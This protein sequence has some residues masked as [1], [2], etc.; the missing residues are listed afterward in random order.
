[1]HSLEKPGKTSEIGDN[2]SISVFP[3]VIYFAKYLQQW[4]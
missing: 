1:M 3:R 2:P 4:D